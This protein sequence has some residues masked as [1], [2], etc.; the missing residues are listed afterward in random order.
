MVG[1]KWMHK[2]H[3]DDDDEGYSTMWDEVVGCKEH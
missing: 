1:I 3:E 2:S